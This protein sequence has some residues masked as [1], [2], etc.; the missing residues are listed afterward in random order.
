MGVFSQASIIYG[1]ERQFLAYQITFRVK[2]Y[3]KN[4]LIFNGLQIFLKTGIIL[5]QIKLI[6]REWADACSFY[7]QTPCSIISIL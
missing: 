1:K 4:I 5:A 2:D 3:F 6:H 7:W